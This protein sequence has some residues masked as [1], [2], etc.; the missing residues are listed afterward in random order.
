ML[1]LIKTMKKLFMVA[2]KYLLIIITL[3]SIIACKNKKDDSDLLIPAQI[4][5]ENGI[6][7][8][9]AKEYKKSATE[10]EK[11]FFQHPGNRLTPL[12][13]LMQAYSL[14][15]AR[16]YEEAIDILDI[17]I[18]LHPRHE[19]IAYAYYL[20]AL[21]SYVQISEVKLDQSKTQDA[22]DYLNEVIEKF[23]NS[24]YA[25]DAEL[26]IDLVKDHLAGQEMLIGRYYLKN[27]NPIAAIRRFQIVVEYYNSTS[28]IPESLYRLVESNLMLGLK[29]EAKKYDGVL[30]HNYP[31]S[32]WHRYSTNLL[33]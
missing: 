32:V 6:K 28:H 7:Q 11:V 2:I 5:Y 15:L 25:I 24:K 30:Q 8:L 27:K 10:F 17:F 33:K 22:L 14:Y 12:A 29:E 23:P 4:I 20:K 9:E 21:A 31:D 16:E 3:F 1:T 19:D 26:K 18:K 13:E